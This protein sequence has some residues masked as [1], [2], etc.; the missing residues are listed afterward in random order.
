MHKIYRFEV[1]SGH[2]G[3]ILGRFGAGFRQRQVITLDFG[4][5]GIDF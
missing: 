4:V 1:G 2:F 3:A 5:I